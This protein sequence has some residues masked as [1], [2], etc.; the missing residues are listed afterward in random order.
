MGTS[1]PSTVADEDLDRH[2]AEL[3]LKEAKQKAEHYGKDG[4]RAYL[5]NGHSE[6]N[7]P[8]TN[9]RFLSS[10]IRNTD[11]HNK[12]I[13]RA[14]AL[15]AQEVRAEREEQERRERRARAQEAAEAERLRRLMGSSG[16]TD[17]AHNW[18]RGK[19]RERRRRGGSQERRGDYSDEEES[20][21]RS[22]RRERE[23]RHRSRSRERRHRK[24]D[25]RRSRRSK[26][27]DT[28]E[29]KDT[30]ERRRHR[31]RRDRTRSR[32]PERSRERSAARDDDSHRR[33]RRRH[34]TDRNRDA[35]SPLPSPKKRSRSRSVGSDGNT[36]FTKH[37][38][39]RS[40]S[41]MENKD[42]AG[43]QPEKR[44]S[45]QPKEGAT[46]ALTREDELRLQLKRK[47]KAKATAEVS[48]E[49]SSRHTSPGP[50]PAPT[51]RT[52]P[53]T[54][55]KGPSKAS[56]RTLRSPH[57][58]SC[59]PPPPASSPPPLPPPAPP[60]KMD[61]YFESSYDPRLDIAPLT[62]PNVPATGLI[63]DAEFAGW[64]AM[65]EIIRL[66]RE[67]KEDK[68]M[69]ERWGLGKDKGKDKRKKKGEE[70]SS[71]RWSEGGT[72]IMDIEYKKRGS[73]REWDLGKEGL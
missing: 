69:L 2:V 50:R 38:R 31:R 13:L 44:S 52:K 53:G 67:D 30:H 18:D 39:T 70:G 9:K 35:G 71:V 1:L 11:D 47:G 5:Q 51:E 14:Q 36:R 15:A 58:R 72:G 61:K 60:S 3:I 10:I 49:R 62:T 33:R 8:K 24:D 37:T 48:T 20:E 54:A 16:R 4:I 7:V 6:G 68:K 64:D 42:R 55:H 19:E 12:T 32:S 34:S 59:S 43:D 66:R 22:A 65:L 57:S 28:Y 21:Q 40:P 29:D 25:E 46:G 63:N 23:Y 45:S 26:S 27:R 73:V 17:W 41:L 56:S